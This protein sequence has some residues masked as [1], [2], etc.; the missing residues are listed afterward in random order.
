MTRLMVAFFCSGFAAL[1]CQIVWQRMLGVFAGSDTVSAALVVGAFLAG[2]GLGSIIGAKVADRLSPHRAMLGFGLCEAGVALFALV[3]KAFLYDFIAIG[4]AD[5]VEAPMAVFALCF[6]GLMLPT[7]LMGASLPLL[8]R[9]VA[10]DL[11]SVAERI[12]KL[13]GLNTLGAGIGAIAGGWFIVGNLG[14]VGALALA[15]GLDLVAAILALTLLPTLSRAAPAPRAAASVAGAGEPFGGLRL[16]CL[17]VFL[18]GYVIVA[19]E[20]VWV[21]MLGQVGQY[22]AYLFPTIL[23]V[24]LLA[25]GWGMAVASRL[26]RRVKDPRPWFFATQASGFV[27]GGVLLLGLW[28]AMHAT[29]LRDWMAVDMLRFGETQLFISVV[30]IALVVGPPSFL[31]GM[32]FPFV[33]RAVQQDLASVGARVGWVQLANILGNAAGSIGTG[34]VSF[35]FLGTMGTLKLLAVASLALI[36]F[37]WWQRTGARRWPAF[38]AAATATLLIVMPG[39]ARFWERMHNQHPGS[40]AVWGEDRS[41]VAFYRSQA[42]VPGRD[43][44]RFFIMGHGQ[45]NIPF[46]DIHMLLGMLG[47]MIHPNPDR[48]LTIG[49]GSGGTPWGATVNPATREI[50]AIELIRPVIDALEDIAAAQ[51]HSAVAALLRDPRVKLE[52]GDG[53]RALTRGAGRYEVIEAD[54]ILPQSSHSGLLYSREYLEEVRDRLAPGGLYVQWAPTW[55]VV[56]TFA[57]VFPHAVLLKPASIMIGSDRPI[58]LD[59]QALVAALRDGHA[60][61]HAARGNPRATDLGAMIAGPMQVWTPATPRVEA[62]LTDMF[63]RDEF[64]LNQPVLATNQARR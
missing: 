4:L 61:A 18:S 35:H 15:S 28:W 6:A 30:L 38:A 52:Y 1:L 47:P 31:I 23:G 19:L 8:S 53:R 24:F 2:L 9:A 51:P 57:A 3:S 46:L 42:E 49:I 59:Q 40:F 56:D 34:L 26:L 41:G 22:H 60:V 32:T 63:P 62:P 33:Q 39:N 44:G 45:G 64:F 7:T 36:A 37:W 21:R 10:T 25:D 55:R 48:V 13:Y 54:A 5:D 58:P 43:P 29:P 50:R 16:W 12:G 14:Y 27:L 17:L 20:I 11:S